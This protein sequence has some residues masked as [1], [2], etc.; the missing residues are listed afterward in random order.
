[1]QRFFCRPLYG[2]TALL[3]WGC[4]QPPAQQA[5]QPA[6][7]QPPGQSSHVTRAALSG[8]RQRVGFYAEVNPDCSSAGIPAVRV[9]ALP[10]HGTVVTAQGEAYTNYPSS[11]QR[12]ACNAIKSRMM[13]VFYTSVPGY[14][15]SDEFVVRTIFADGVARTDQYT[16]NVE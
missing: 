1:M 8:T 4:T 9:E 6:A 16:M 13:E 2:L 12:Y 14:R 15:G 3:L 11:N 7:T 10:A 5:Q